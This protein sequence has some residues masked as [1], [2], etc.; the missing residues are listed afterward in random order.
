LEKAL[1]E[2]PN[3]ILE[4]KGQEKSGMLIGKKKES[5]FERLEVATSKAQ[6]KGK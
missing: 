1:F 5:T 3:R 4:S 6:K 2:P